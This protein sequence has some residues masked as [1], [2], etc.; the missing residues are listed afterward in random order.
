MKTAKYNNLKIGD[1]IDFETQ[2][3]KNPKK[4]NRKVASATVIELHKRVATCMTQF[5]YVICV[6]RIRPHT[7]DEAK[8]I[9]MHNELMIALQK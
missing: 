1:V 4:G 5:G 6:P 7:C 3:Y 8:D 2:E 9:A